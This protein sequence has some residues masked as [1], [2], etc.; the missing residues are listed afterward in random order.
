MTLKIEEPAGAKRDSAFANLKKLCPV[1]NLQIDAN[2][3]ITTD[4]A[5][6]C[7][8]EADPP[9]PHACRCICDAI[10]SPK[11]ISIVVIDDLT[12][13]DGGA[14]AALEIDKA[15]P[16]P[17]GSNGDGTDVA[18]F[19]ENQ[20][21][22]QVKDKDGNWIDDPDWIILGHELCGHAVPYAYGKHVEHRPGKPGYDPDWHSDAINK[23]NEIRDDNR[24]P[25]REGNA[26]RKKP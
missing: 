16:K 22:W 13:K 23:E 6:F 3:I 10:R 12:A 20:D 14:S 7:T 25:L 18:V 15:F 24:L 17:N 1:A 5:D 21:R 4:E 8:R 26:T 19:I 11:T 9:L 2:G